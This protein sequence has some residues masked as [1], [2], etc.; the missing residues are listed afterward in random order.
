[1]L[2]FFGENTDFEGEFLERKYRFFSQEQILN[3]FVLLLSFLEERIDDEAVVV[4]AV[5][6]PLM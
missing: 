5:A 1:M 3:G 6:R 4:H 2:P